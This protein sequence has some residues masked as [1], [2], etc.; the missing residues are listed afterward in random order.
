[1]E[2]DAVFSQNV[3][4][5]DRVAGPRRWQALLRS[6]GCAVSINGVALDRSVF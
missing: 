5:V 1:M 6:G 3:Q 4:Y 2:T